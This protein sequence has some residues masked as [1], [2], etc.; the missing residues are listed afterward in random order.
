[1]LSKK[2]IVIII[3]SVCL[4]ILGISVW[5]LIDFIN[6]KKNDDPSISAYSGIFFIITNSLIIA[7]VVIG[8]AIMI[9]MLYYKPKEKPFKFEYTGL[10][11]KPK[12]P[13]EDYNLITETTKRTERVPGENDRII[14]EI[15]YVTVNHNFYPKTSE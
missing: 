5:S 13:F 10:N 11:L 8:S 6:K 1:M 9:W 12:D 14:N 2:S 4:V 15:N 3:L 7:T